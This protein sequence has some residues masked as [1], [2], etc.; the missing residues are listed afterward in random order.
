LKS[1]AFRE[2]TQNEILDH[3]LDYCVPKV[4]DTTAVQTSDR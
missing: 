4:E 3:G 2:T 1:L